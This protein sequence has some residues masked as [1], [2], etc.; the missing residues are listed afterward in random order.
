ME[1]ETEW[2]TGNYLIGIKKSN[3]H[4]GGLGAFALNTIPKNSMVRYGGKMVKE[5][6]ANALCSWLIDGWYLDGSKVGIEEGWARYVNHSLNPNMI[7]CYS[8][9]KHRK[10]I[11]YRTIREIGI[12]E[13]LYVDYG[14]VYH[15]YLSKL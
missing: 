11:Y 2:S 13:E 1:V 15:D 10:W 4:G 14:K 12:G 5:F 7:P 9:Y 6:E 3:I 8:S